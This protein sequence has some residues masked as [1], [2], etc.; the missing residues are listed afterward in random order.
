MRAKKHFGQHF[1][2]NANTAS[3][4]VECLENIEASNVLEVGPGMGV[5]T[6][7][8]NDKAA[9]FKVVEIDDEAANYVQAK[10]PKLEIVR[11]DFLKVDFETY[12]KSSFSII[13]NFPY[14]ISSQIVF[15]IMENSDQVEQWV[16]MFQLEMG[17]RLIAEPH[18]KQYGILSVLLPFYYKVEKVMTLA[19]AAFNPP[20]KVTSIVL[21]AQRVEHDFKCNQKILKQVVKTAFNQRRKV[22]SNSLSSIIPKEALNTSQFANLRP[23]NLN[24]QQFEELSEFIE[25]HVG[26]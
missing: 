23:E 10:W 21:K 3:R 7:F 22:L 2:T 9:D 6:Q 25:Q 19:P 26:N 13:G 12:F 11:G 18:N 24:P 4:I 5:L 20:P 17:N 1:L 14:N 8:L 15:K 16:G